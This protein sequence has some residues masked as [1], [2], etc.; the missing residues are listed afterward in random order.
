[1]GL[2]SLES[3]DGFIETNRDNYLAYSKGLAGLSGTRLI[4]YDEK[5]KNNYQYIVLEVEEKDA[6]LGRDLLVKILHA[7]NILVRR[8]FYPGCHQMEPYRSYFPNAGLVLPETEKLTLKVLQLP[9]GTAVGEKEI[10]DICQLIRYILANAA[11]IR[12]QAGQ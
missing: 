10:V 2:T 1:M 6:G 3:M 8:Y 12:D 5:E 4:K 9:T 11:E 7:E